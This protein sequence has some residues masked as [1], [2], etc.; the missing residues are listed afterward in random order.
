MLE[1]TLKYKWDAKGWEYNISNRKDGVVGYFVR[2]GVKHTTGINYLEA[3]GSDIIEA[4][5]R[6]DELALQMESQRGQC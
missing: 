5:I 1:L 4:C 6:A 3:S 2:L